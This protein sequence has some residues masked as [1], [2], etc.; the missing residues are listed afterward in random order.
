MV[1]VANGGVVD[2]D[3]DPENDTATV[4]I[5]DDDATTVSIAATTAAA[6]EPSTNGQ[7]TVTLSKAKVGIRGGLVAGVHAGAL[8]T[9]DGDYTALSGMVTILEG[10]S[11]AVI[12]V[13]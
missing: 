3:S 6:A 10:H 11:S 5:A 9:A 8:A 2:L 7:F 13:S 4:N 1:E 12:N